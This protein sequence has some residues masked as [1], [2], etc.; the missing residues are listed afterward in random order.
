[1]GAVNSIWGNGEDLFNIFLF[2]FFSALDF[3]P[4]NDLFFFN[5]KGDVFAFIAAADIDGNVIKIA[6]FKDG[7]QIFAKKGR[8][9]FVARSVLDMTE[10]G[11]GVDAGIALNSNRCDAEKTVSIGDYL[12]S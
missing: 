11:T 4:G 5:D 7:A 8:V 1:M 2:Y 10:N 6:H 3:H 12:F 9:V